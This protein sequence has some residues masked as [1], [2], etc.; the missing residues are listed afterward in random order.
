MLK[1]AVYVLALGWHIFLDYLDNNILFQKLQISFRKDLL[2]DL[3]SDM[4]I[5]TMY[6][7]VD[8]FSGYHIIQSFSNRLDI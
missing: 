7:G 2:S 3:L 5:E 6:L 8:G 4:K 1:I